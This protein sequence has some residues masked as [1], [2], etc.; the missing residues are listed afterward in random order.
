MRILD[1]KV[2]TI[3]EPFKIAHFLW[4]FF[5]KLGEKQVSKFKV[6]RF[7]WSQVARLQ[8]CGVARSDHHCGMLRTLEL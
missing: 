6:A 1:T 2:P 3:V 4:S 7:Q 8:S 5:E